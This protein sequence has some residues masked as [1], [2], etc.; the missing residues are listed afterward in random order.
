MCSVVGQAQPEVVERHLELGGAQ[1]ARHLDGAVEVG[2]RLQLGDLQFEV[3]VV[4]AGGAGRRRRA[5]RRRSGSRNWR[6]EQVHRHAHAVRRGVRGAPAA[7]AP[8]RRRAI[9]C[10]ADRHDGAGLLEQRHEDVRPQQPARRMPPAQQRLGPHDRAVV[11]IDGRLEPHLELVSADRRRQVRG[12][13]HELRR[14]RPGPNRRRAASRPA[15]GPW[16]G[17][18]RSRRRAAC[19]RPSRARR[20]WW[21]CRCSPRRTAAVRRPGTARPARRGCGSATRS[22]SRASLRFESTTAHSSPPSGGSATSVGVPSWPWLRADAGHQVAVAQAARHAPQRL[23]QQRVAAVVAELLVQRA[24]AVEVDQ[25]QREPRR[26]GDGA[27]A[28]TRRVDVRAQGDH[29]GQAGQRVGAVA[30]GA[31][32]PGC[33]PARRRGRWRRARPRRSPPPSGRRRCGCAPDARRRTAG[34][35]PVR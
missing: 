4:E 24:E 27:A 17:P 9:A 12:E 18:A 5:G 14:R 15:R 31:R 20:C 21:R 16:R 23:A 29:A 25:Q 10:P 11:Q 30:L 28:C 26:R 3:A 7:P 32:R 6:A 2:H 33:R 13:L 22:A 34:V 19:L 8:R 35:A 1:R